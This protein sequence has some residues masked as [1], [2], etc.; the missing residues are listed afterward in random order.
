MSAQIESMHCHS[1]MHLYHIQ[2]IATQPVHC[3]LRD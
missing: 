2:T 3:L 1:L